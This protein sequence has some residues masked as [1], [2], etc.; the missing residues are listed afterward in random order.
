[1]PKSGAWVKVPE[2]LLDDPTYM[3]MRPTLRA[4]LLDL[5]LTCSKEG[6]NEDGRL[7]PVNDLAWALRQDVEELETDMHQL[8]ELGYLNTRKGHW[9][10]VALVE[11][12]KPSPSTLRWRRWY[13]KQKAAQTKGVGQTLGQHLTNIGSPQDKDQ[14]KDKDQDQ[15]QDKDQQQEWRGLISP[16]LQRTLALEYAQRQ[17]QVRSPEAYARTLLAG[18]WEPSADDLARHPCERTGQVSGS[19]TCDWCSG[20][21]RARYATP[22]V[23]EDE[24]LPETGGVDD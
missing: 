3:R 24:P 1:M 6:T 10:H 14:D 12:Q 7:P 8:A 23:E 20:V 13:E 11:W 4:L 16:E 22:E 15:D 9:F 5:A 18:G 19:C 17:P 2:A 21:R